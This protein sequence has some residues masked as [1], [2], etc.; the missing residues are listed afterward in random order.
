MKVIVT[1]SIEHLSTRPQVAVFAS[2]ACADPSDQDAW[3]HMIERLWPKVAR[4]P[5]ADANSWLLQVLWGS[6]AGGWQLMQK[7]D[8]AIASLVAVKLR[9]RAPLAL[10]SLRALVKS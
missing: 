1:A 10:W 6:D 9:D 7:H 4:L 8:S 5:G 3:E 2:F